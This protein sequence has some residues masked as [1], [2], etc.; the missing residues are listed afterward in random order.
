MTDSELR[1]IFDN[2]KTAI[3]QGIQNGFNNI[4]GSGT[5][6]GA[7]GGRTYSQ[8]YISAQIARNLERKNNITGNDYF[9]R[10]EKR[11]IDREN[12]R[13]SEIKKYGYDKAAARKD[14]LN[15]VTQIG[16]GVVDIIVAFGEKEIAYSKA[17]LEKN[18]KI[19]QVNLQKQTQVI[20]QG[21]KSITSSFTKNAVDVS[22]DFVQASYDIAKTAYSA[23]M[24][25]KIAEKT[26]N[27][28]ISEANKN[29]MTGIGAG[30]VAIGAGIGTLIAPGIGTAIG[31][32]AGG[33]V[34]MWSKVW[35]LDIKEK[36]LRIQQLEQVK[37]IMDNYLDSFKQLAQPWDDLTKQSTDFVLKLNDSGLK[38]SRTIGYTSDDFANTMIGMSQVTLANGKTMAEIFGNEVE[39]IPEYMDA[40]IQSASRAVNL[41]ATA[42]GNIMSTARLFG[43]SGGEASSLYGSMNIFNTS[44]NSASDS[45]NVIY[46]QITKM[47]L[48]SKKFGKDLVENLKLAQK[49]N[50]K[51]GV[52]NMMKLTKWAQQTR[53]NLNSAASFADSIMNDSLSGAL[54]K[55]AKLQVLGGSAAIYSDP[56]GMLYDA[57]ADVGNMAQRMASMFNDITGTFNRKTGETEFNWYENRMLAARAQAMGMDVGEV[58]NMIRQQN[59]QG[60]IDR[61]LR[62]SGLDEESRVAIGN[63]ATYDKKNKRWV[64][65]DIHGNEHDI[66]EYGK[67]GSANIEDLLPA[68]TQEAMLQVAE[69]S[70]SHLERLDYAVVS[71]MTK[72]GNEKLSTIYETSDTKNKIWQEFFKDNW[73]GVGE[74]WEKSNQQTV[75]LA[76]KNSQ[77]MKETLD[78]REIIENIY[79]GTLVAVSNTIKEIT[80]DLL[81]ASQAYRDGILQQY[82]EDKAGVENKP[83]LLER[84]KEWIQNNWKKVGT[85]AALVAGGSMPHAI[86][87]GYENFVKK[88]N[89][90]FGNT[91]GGYIVGASNVKSINDGGV[92]VRTSR[93]DQ[94]LAAETGGPIDKILQQLIPGLQALLLN[95]NKNSNS[96]SAN[97][98]I[99]GKLELS[100]DGSTLNLVE[101]IKN[102]PAMGP[103]FIYALMKALGK[104]V[105]NTKFL[106]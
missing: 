65:T 5:S 95:D 55:S 2:F 16:K 37:N 79:T 52:D 46:K 49:Y 63:R 18:V 83:L 51:G 28:A 23:S 24:E 100:Q 42:M 98:N 39:K 6:S 71:R 13:L 64:V 60:V 27:K 7:T 76:Y 69:K 74:M 97:I 31:A 29:L 81:L 78:N 12:K 73:T 59:K 68:D 14:V 34:G 33:I 1:N 40:Y 58:R 66:R 8:D 89:D 101:L 91:N 105:Y 104:P 70:L 35:G 92:N 3:E 32:I 15:A 96:N 103:Q 67:G 61:V 99:N 21:M 50:F 88:Q 72:L 22:Y 30:A 90:G 20:S 86:H 93:R 9:D 26:Y 62:G 56:L 17:Y 10:R 84:T 94:Y 43:M 48:S 77:L 25:F 44:V 87:Y 4:P 38:F 80:G 54:E 47:G 85:T 57:G 82:S 19:T 53:F 41:N 75:D 106:G 36:E 102:N 11:K 45:M